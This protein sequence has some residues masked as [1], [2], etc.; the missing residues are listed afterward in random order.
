MP[1]IS[2]LIEYP[3]PIDPASLCG[4]VL[5]RFL[6]RP[7]WD[8]MAVV[9][10]GRP[11]GVVGRGAIIARDAER[12]VAEV[13]ASVLT[14]GPDTRVDEA[15]A[16]LLA[17]SEPLAGL[18]VVDGARYIG[19]VSA[20]AL[21]RLKCDA[22]PGAEDARRFAEMVGRELHTPLGGVL[23]VA[24]LLQR[25]PLS[26]DAQS[27]VRTIIESG[28][29]M[30]AALDAARLEQVFDGLIG[31]A[32]SLARRGAIEAS[33][34]VQRHG[35]NLRLTGRVRD[36]G[37]GLSAARISQ[38]FETGGGHGGLSLALCRRIVERLGGQIR[39]E[40]NV[41]AGATIVF[42]FP[43]REAIAVIDKNAS[44]NATVK[45]SA[46]VLV[47][48]DSDIT[49]DV[50]H[51]ILTGEGAAVTLASQRSNLAGAAVQ[52]AV[53]GLGAS[54]PMLVIGS[55]SQAALG[56]SKGLLRVASR[57]G[58]QLLGVVLVGLGALI[59]THADRSVE[60]WLVGA[61]PDWLT[62]LTTRF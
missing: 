17:H 34:Q 33:L 36:T 1:S 9:E 28:E 4:S 62:T 27:Y 26:A 37:G 54:V 51:R 35:D 2:R 22:E 43:A 40:A 42:D 12:K 47:V 59:I 48:D 15:C 29:A 13:M 3:D 45:R 55:A 7:E 61:S 30:A 60:A 44:A 6:D 57:R 16:L 18:V 11:R 39:A 41:G 14:I 21:L 5:D 19:V 32:L 50:A 8:L 52:M 49:R 20:R 56:R 23:A 10:G 53:F 58:K 38:A 24:D 46:H 25:Q 31:A